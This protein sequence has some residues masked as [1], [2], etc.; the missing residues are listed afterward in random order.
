MKGSAATRQVG[1]P[2]V[3]VVGRPNVGKSSLVN[4]ILGRREAI[5]DEQ[6]GVTRDRRG[7]AAEWAGRTF[8]IV[9]T[10]G[11]EPGARGIGARVSE[12]AHVA[13]ATADVIVFVVDAV[14][15]PLQDDLEVARALRRSGKPVIVAVNKVDAT[16]LEPLAAAYHRLGL[17]EPAPVS[18]L[19]GRRSGDLLERIV[20]A[21]P[22]ETEERSDAWATIAIVGRPNVGK[23][24]ILNAL[25]GETRA[26]VDPTPG[27][28]RDPVDSFIE[29]DDDDRTLRVLDTAGMR[30]RTHIEDPL[31]YFAFLR[32]R[33]TLERVD[34]AV[35][36]VDMAEGVTGPD[37]RI[38]SEIVE[39]GRA[40][41]LCLNKWDLVTSE[42]PDRDR[43]ERATR[44]GLRFVEW[45]STVRTSALTKRGIDR[46]LPAVQ[47]AIE[48]HRRR[49][50]T[51]MVNRIVQDAQ[52]KRPHPRSTG[53]PVR[54]LYAV[55]ART[56]PP[57]ILLFATGRLD[58][59]YVRYLEREVRAV[60]PFHGS[61]LRLETRL[62][63]RD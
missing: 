23:S 31:E 5:V 45:A 34:A 51:A 59:S 35:L 22:S 11:L 1:V 9:D 10:G 43:L 19:H 37:Q 50:P 17:G 4:R 53:R 55:Q 40:C 44:S 56:G 48:S 18:A 38:A 20:A 46:L 30:R 21:L 12:Q 26:I 33:R 52:S 16:E 29:L 32:S 28:T 2:V 36:V 13:I 6:P 57:T 58:A 8:E 14:S 41:V 49:I 61:P 63:R 15:G 42:G 54:V 60:E 24:S 27:T 39:N 7:F 25:L 47:V 3:A 62:K